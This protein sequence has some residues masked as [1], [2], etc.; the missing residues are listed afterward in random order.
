MEHSWVANPCVAKVCGAIYQHPCKIAWVGDYVENDWIPNTPFTGNMLWKMEAVE[1]KSPQIYLSS[2]VHE[3]HSDKLLVNHSKKLIING[4]EYIE[5]N[6]KDD[7][8]VHP[9]P[10]LTACGNGRGGGDY[11]GSDMD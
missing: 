8:C 3:S 2:V 4:K 10:L 9:L 1:I 7:W 5:R 6:T 11:H